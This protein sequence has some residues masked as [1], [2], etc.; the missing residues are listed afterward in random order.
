MRA[1]LSEYLLKGVFLGLLFYVSLLDRNWDHT[2]E[3]GLGVAIGLGA[4]IVLAFVV[5][6]RDAVHLF[7][8]PHT[9]LLFL[10]LENPLLIYAGLIFGLAGAWTY[11]WNT[12]LD[13]KT[14]Y[15]CILGG[16]ALGYGINELRSVADWRYRVAFIILVGVGLCYGIDG[17]FLKLPS[18]P[19]PADREAIGAHLIFGL[20]LL[21]L[22]IFT[23]KAE[24]SEA[25][26]GILCAFLGLAL[27]LMNPSE[28]M[29]WVAIAIPLGIFLAY[30]TLVLPYL[31]P[32]KHTLRGYCYM[33]VQKIRPALISFRKALALNRRYRLAHAGMEAVHLKIDIDKLDPQTLALLDRELCLNRA[34]TLLNQKPNEDDRIKAERF[35]N[36]VEKQWPKWVSHAIYFRAVMAIHQGNLDKAAELLTDLLAPEGWFADDPQRKEI[37]FDAWQLV[38]LV[39]PTLKQRVG[40]V[41]IDLPGRRIEAI[42]A[43][44]RQI[45]KVGADQVL[46]DFRAI[47]YFPLQ[48]E[49]FWV[50]A[51]QALPADFGYGFV[52]QVG[53]G[54]IA[55]RE[56]WRR[57]AEFLRIAAAGLVAHRPTIYQKLAEAHARSSETAEAENYYRQVRDSALEIGVANLPAD[58]KKAYFATVKKLGE[59]ARLRGELDEAIY[60]FSL[61]SQTDDGIK[62]TLRALAA[63]YEKKDDIFN[64]LRVNEK[65]MIYDSK[66]ADLLQR[67]SRYYSWVKP[68]ELREAAKSDPNV[69]KYFDV[70]YCIRQAKNI[71]DTSTPENLD[72]LDWAEHLLSLALVLQPKRMTA[73]V[74]K[75]R[76]L[77]RRG[78]QMEAVQILEDVR[79][80]RPSGSDEA[81]AWSFTLKQLGRIYLDELNPPR[82]DLAV[83]CFEE[84]CKLNE[85]GAQSLFDLGRAHEAN[86]NVAEA[87]RAYTQVTVYD[88]P[89]T[90]EAK[91]AIRRLK[92]RRGDTAASIQ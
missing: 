78:E 53:M 56:Q 70:E 84:F 11:C 75:A 65:A 4:A 54:L 26:I 6:I 19:T 14:F 63:V 15:F 55:D 49:E 1:Y 59:D 10:L 64:A 92:E 30:T 67:K 79:E 29:R 74:I 51:R 68:E 89:L 61:A 12:A 66:D 48:E 80:G 5:Q 35:L 8:K 33:D 37:L 43:L 69:F 82:P 32:F 13:D 81:A 9:T 85:S 73:Q 77:L 62:E 20:P 28:E 21:Y 34:R 76:C 16:L 42:G 3:L 58:Q 88:H 7:R 57:G 52:E 22:L 91:E 47:L 72:N 38:L 60:N 27:Y 87:I 46:Q 90:Y 83:S 39:H 36:L 86:G 18:V 71:L 45:A 44:E 2:S 17:M 31:R 24:E 41:Q 40:E 23:A 25:D 50:V